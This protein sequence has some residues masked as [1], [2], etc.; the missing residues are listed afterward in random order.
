MGLPKVVITIGNGTLG[1]TTTTD[2]GVA[3]LIVS[4]TAITAGSGATG[5]ALATPVQLFS[6]QQFL[7]IG[8]T[9]VNNPI[10][11]ADVK[12]FYNQAGNGSELW[13]MLITDATLLGALCDNTTVGTSIK[14]LLD[15][16]ARRIRLLGVNRKKPATGYTSVYT[17]NSGGVDDDCFTAIGKLEATRAIYAT[18]YKPFRAFICGQGY[19]TTAPGTLSLKAGANRGV[20]VLLGSSAANMVQVGIVLGRYA[21]IPVQRSGA[22]VKDGDLG[23][24]AAC[25]PDGVAVNSM[26]ASWDANIDGKGYVFFRN[27]YGKSGFY[28]SNDITATADSDDYNTIQNG[29]VIDKAAVIAYATLVNELNDDIDVDPITG[30]ISAGII[31]SWKAEVENALNQNMNANLSGKA[32][33]TI[34]PKQ[35]LLSSNVIAMSIKLV[36]KGYSKEIDISLSYNNPFKTT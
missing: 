29:R 34:N 23:I 32:V 15:A 4:G 8:F 7:N 9:A 10:A 12:D 33:A 5:L 19:V 22:R 13:L 6:W 2:D 24:I 1:K 14:T 26:E 36:P 28:I 21:A 20:Q 17:V 27:F 30:Y 3:G 25:F 31:A 16:A 35:N 11:Y 18:A